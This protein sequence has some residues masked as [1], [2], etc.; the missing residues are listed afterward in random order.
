MSRSTRRAAPR[1]HPAA[2]SRS[3][4]PR[5]NACRPDLADARLAGR[6]EAAR[7]V[8]G[9]LREVV[10]P[11]TALRR[12][13][14]RDAP[15]ESEALA[16]EVVRAFE[17][18]ADGWSWVQLGRDRHVGYVETVALAA[19][20]A[21]PTHR[22]VVPRS[23]V[24][25]APDVKSPPLSWLPLGARFAA[26]AHDERFVALARGG[27]LVARHAAPLGAPPAPDFVA[28]A[29]EF[30]SV[31][32]LW[33]GRTGLGLDCSGLV[34]VALD[35]AG[36]AAPRDSDMQEAELGTAINDRANLRRGDLVFWKGHVGAMRDA[37]ILV[38]ANGHH[39]QVAAEPLA[40]AEARIAA[41]GG[42]PV[43]SIRRL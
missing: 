8:E 23:F 35:A 32:Y 37:R 22:L 2:M 10:A 39:M 4:D 27:F 21:A 16:G 20:G 17:A 19:P 38:H 12:H 42:G 3:L 9:T 33:G 13:P 15:L 36:I 1:H 5:R 7:F 28:V 26:A 18:R 43:T 11:V 24:Y 31:P 6:V 34:Q 30:L 41:R 25:P 14:A 29:E 40:E